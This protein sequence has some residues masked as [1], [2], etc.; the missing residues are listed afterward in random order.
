MLRHIGLFLGV[1]VLAIA[2]SASASSGRLKVLTYNV[3]GLPDGFSTPHPSLNLPRIGS[4]LGGY[5]LALIQEDFAYPSALRKNLILPY[6]SPAFERGEQMHFG[7]GLSLFSS[8]SFTPLQRE[9]WQACYGYIDSFFDCL[10][11]KGFTRT[12]MTL[13]PGVHVDV[14]NIHLDAGWGAKDAAARESQVEQ[15]VHAIQ[16]YSPGAALLVGGDTN[17]PFQQRTLLERFRKQTG[18]S[19]ACA[20]L[21]CPEPKR[22]DRVLFRSSSALHWLPRKWRIDPRF[23]DENLRPLSDHLAVAVDLDWQTSEPTAEAL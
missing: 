6:Q 12:R 4:L 1:T 15:L 2:S 23:V 21:R 7:D 22:I 3:A 5:D 9:A 18:L 13:A 17:I 11:P 20:A 10:T 16:Q 8:Y 19:D 14:Y